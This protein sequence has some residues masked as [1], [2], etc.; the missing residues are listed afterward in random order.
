MQR[1]SNPLGCFPI[2]KT[3]EDAVMKYVY[4]AILTQEDDGIIVSFP[5]VEGAR[6]D[7]ATMEEALENAEDVLNLMLLT[8]EEKHMD[9]KPPTPIAS[10]DVPKGSTVALVRADTRAYSKK[11]DT[12]AVRKSVSIPAWMDSLAREHNLNFSNVLQ[13]AICRELNIAQ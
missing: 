4:P 5:D 3:E 13:N 6:T 11:V 12:R 10:L 9:I 2:I 8:M 7:G 1:G